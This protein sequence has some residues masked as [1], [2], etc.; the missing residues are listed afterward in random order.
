[1]SIR[2]V[3]A[4]RLAVVAAQASLFGSPTLADICDP[5]MPYAG[6]Q[7][8]R[9]GGTGPYWFVTD[10][11]SVDADGA[12]NAYHPDDVG[13]PCG[14][15]GRGLDCPANAGYPD[16]SWWPDVL[17]PD[18]A[19]PTRAYVQPSGTFEGYFVSKT[20]LQDGSREEHDA[21]KYVDATRIPYLVFPGNFYRLRGTGRLGDVGVA[22]HV[23]SGLT[24]PFIVADIGPSSAA[25][26]EASIALFENLGGADVNP[27]N[28]VG[29]PRGEILYVV[30]PYQRVDERRPWPAS[31][32]DIAATTE[33][34]T[35][36][37]GGLERITECAAD[38]RD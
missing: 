35:I 17:V 13:K 31:P 20:A 9:D 38:L 4:V 27:R 21:A 23:D 24:S 18:P 25:L 6:T 34:L 30:F 32:R 29:L 3:N 14:A 26:G 16:A 7:L 37:L 22:V 19:D 8:Y 2:I 5:W 1:M 11:K 28:G 15:S 12:P 36:E 33:A 10:H